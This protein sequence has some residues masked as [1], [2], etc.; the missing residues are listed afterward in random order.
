MGAMIIFGT[1]RYLTSPTATF[2]QFFHGLLFDRMSMQNL[3]SV[4]LPVF[5]IIRGTQKICGAGPDLA[6]GGLGPS[7]GQGVA[8]SPPQKKNP[9][10]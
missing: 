4:A 1:T 6:G 7:L 3:K 5:E 9:E 8:P 2:P 10:K